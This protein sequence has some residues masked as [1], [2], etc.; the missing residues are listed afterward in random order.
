MIPRPRKKDYHTCEYCK[1][2]PCMY[3]IKG[4]VEYGDHCKHYQSDTA[5]IRREKGKWN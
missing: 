5:K 2:K 3:E 4:E 1:I